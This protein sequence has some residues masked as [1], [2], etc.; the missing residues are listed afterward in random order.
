MPSEYEEDFEAAKIFFKKSF[1]AT[2]MAFSCHSWLLNEKLREFLS[3]KSNI[4]SFMNKFEIV[5]TDFHEVGNYNQIWR[6]FDVD[7]NGN[8][9]NL[10]ADTSLRCAFKKYLIE[11]GKW[12]AGYGIFFA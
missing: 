2:P 8:L 4:I 5:Y 3:E 12:G 6:L 7:Y 9:Q 10:P 11:G 1:T